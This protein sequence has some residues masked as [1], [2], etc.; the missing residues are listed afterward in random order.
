[1]ALGVGVCRLESSKL[2]VHVGVGGSG[3]AG[4]VHVGIGVHVG[5]MG[6][7]VHDGIGVTVGK[8]V[9]EGA[10]VGVGV[11]ANTLTPG[12]A[13]TDEKPPGAVEVTIKLELTLAVMTTGPSSGGSPSAAR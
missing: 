9:T 12:A 4:D 2:R 6:V 8:G 11:E 1:M 3:V 10:V 13:A 7:G 5:V